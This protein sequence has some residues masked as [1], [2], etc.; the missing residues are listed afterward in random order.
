MKNMT[1][2]N[3]KNV[4]DIEILGILSHI[5]KN[6][7]H[8]KEQIRMM[9]VCSM[10]GMRSINFRY[11]QV[12]N[13]YDPDTGAVKDKICLDSDKNKGKFPATYWVNEQFATELAKYY[14]YL[15]TRWGDKLGPDTYLFTSQKMNKPYNRVSVCRIFHDVYNGCGCKDCCT[16]WGRR[17]FVTRLCRKGADI[18]LIKRLVNHKSIA[19]TQAYYNY[20]DESLK[21]A[22]KLAAF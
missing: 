17:L 11:L 19:T 12:K 22:A 7:K 6:C 16:H 8:H 4:T 9:V 14:K 13:C 15:K 18:C 20:D 5:D 21:N 10:N 1:N 3:R 2:K